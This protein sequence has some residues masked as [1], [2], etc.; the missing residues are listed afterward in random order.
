MPNIDL[1]LVI[2]NQEGDRQR[3]VGSLLNC[4]LNPPLNRS[5]T[6][7]SCDDAEL[8]DQTK[9]YSGLPACTSEGGADTLT[10]PLKRAAILALGWVL[11][12]GGI[13]GLFL[14]VVPGGFL[15]VAGAH[16]LSPQYAWLRQALE[17]YRARSHVLGRGVEWLGMLRTRVDGARLAA[18]MVIR[19]H[20][21]GVK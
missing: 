19:T 14:P 11:V 18:M 6:S 15:I 5:A 8:A 2:C 9:S 10:K 3:V 20:V 16:M 12:L 1:G 17:K 4:R 13:I 7:R 21:L